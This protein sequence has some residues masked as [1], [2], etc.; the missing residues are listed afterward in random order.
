LEER[1]RHVDERRA[2]GEPTVI[3]QPGGSPPH[4]VGVLVEDLSA[5]AQQFEDLLGLSFPDK[6]TVTLEGPP[7]VHHSCTFVYSSQGPPYI[8][9]IEAQDDGPWARHLG[10]GLHHIGYAG[11]DGDSTLRRL[12]ART[13]DPGLVLSRV[14]AS[15]AVYLRPE[16]AANVR[17]ELLCPPGPGSG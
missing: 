3:V 15:T 16:L 7:G 1:W 17:V 12:S 14:E 8:E 2:I 4:H 10:L 6:R 13:D 9:L 5:A 11:I